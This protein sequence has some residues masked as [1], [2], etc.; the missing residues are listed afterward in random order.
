MTLQQANQFAITLALNTPEMTSEL[1]QETIMSQFPS[2]TSN[3][4]LA[5]SETFYACSTLKQNISLLQQDEAL[6]QQET[7]LLQQANSLLSDALRGSKIERLNIV[8][9]NGYRSL[10]HCLANY[11]ELYYSE[12]CSDVGKMVGSGAVKYA[13]K[14]GL[15]VI[16]DGKFVYDSEGAISCDR[17]GKP[18][19]STGVYFY[20]INHEKFQQWLDY[21]VNRY[22]KSLVSVYDLS[23][24]EIDLRFELVTLNNRITFIS[25]NE[26]DTKDTLKE[27]V[28]IL[29]VE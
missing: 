21:V 8:T 27:L 1:F 13:R 15:P 6:L 26:L 7:T 24:D 14:I 9:G 5:L 23:D 17:T 28:K 10:S 2:L 3:E 12:P 19:R 11:A 29:E 16:R 20:D 18:K 25:K 22:K 4:F